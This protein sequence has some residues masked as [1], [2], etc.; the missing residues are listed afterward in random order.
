ML[1]NTSENQEGT[2]NTM[3]DAGW[4]IVFVLVLAALIAFIIAIVLWQ[5][6]KTQ[7]TKL[8][9]RDAIARDEN[10]RKLAE[11]SASFHEEIATELQT[12][13]TELTET[14]HRVRE[15]ERILKEVG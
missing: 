6:F 2:W 8:S 11:K 5:V 12:L 15:L 9:N 14:H 10:Y 7:Q 3:G 13:R 4:G 1:D